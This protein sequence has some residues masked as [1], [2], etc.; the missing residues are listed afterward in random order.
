M[1][2]TDISKRRHERQMK[3]ILK[4]VFRVSIL[5]IIAGTAAA[6]ILTKDLWYPRLGGI[7]SSDSGEQTETV[8]AAGEFPIIIPENK[9]LSVKLITDGFAMLTD[10]RLIT[11]TSAGKVKLSSSHTFKNPVMNCS[12]DD[13]IT[14]DLGGKKFSYFKKNKL[15]FTKET[16][17]AILLGRVKNGYTAVVTESDKFL[18]DVFVY[19]AN[20]NNIFNLNTTERLIDIMFNADCSGIYITVLNS[21]SGDLTSQIMYYSLTEITKDENG[22]ALPL[23]QTE[24]YPTLS[25]QTA[26]F[27]DDKLILIGD[28]ETL[29]FDY[30]CRLISQ[31]DYSLSLKTFDC[32]KNTAMLIFE[33]FSGKSVHFAALNAL[34]GKF[35]E[36]TSD[37]EIKDAV[38]T[39]DEQGEA[40]IFILGE[41]EIR[42]INTLNTELRNLS[43]TTE[44]LNIMSNGKYIYLIGFE[45]INRITV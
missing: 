2:I 33:D 22:N 28:R 43:L 13:I 27:G 15:G 4:I 19:D 18:G 10:T 45:E 9:S 16:D 42:Q 7:L 20:G 8:L 37:F 41:N 3:K 17:R 30:Q 6:V 44:F 5:I 26:M 24:E 29:V 21:K 38:C 11:Y 31:L 23:Y 34:D 12:D 40:V 1:A 39:E 32:G 35:L 36:F 25:L 14:Y